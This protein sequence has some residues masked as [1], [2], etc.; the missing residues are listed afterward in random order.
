MLGL[1]KKTVSRR[2]NE[3]QSLTALRVLTPALPGMT[4]LVNGHTGFRTMRTECGTAILMGVLKKPRCAAA[5][6]FLSAGTVVE[7]H[8]HE[9]KEWFIVYQGQFKLEVDGEVICLREGDSYYVAPGTPHSVVETV[10]DTWLLAVTVPAEE[11]FPE[12]GRK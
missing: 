4:E 11:A 5:D 3:S 12:N 8:V 7:D 6:T 1:S 2:L 9:S 10:T